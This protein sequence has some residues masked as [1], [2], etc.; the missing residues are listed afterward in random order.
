MLTHGQRIHEAL[1]ALILVLQDVVEDLQ[2]HAHMA[3]FELFLLL[4]LFIN[5]IAHHHHLIRRPRVTGCNSAA[6]M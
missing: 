6:R 5:F 3:L 4:L 2:Q 1:I